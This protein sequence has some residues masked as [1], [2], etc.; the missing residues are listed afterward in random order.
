MAS[1]LRGRL[2]KADPFYFSWMTFPGAIVAGQMARLPYE[3]VC[4]DM[5][6]GLAGF[7]DVASMSPAITASGKPLVLR[8]L[9]NDPGL[10]G[11][12]LDAGATAV[13]VPMVNT[14][15]QAEAVVKA[16]KYAPM[17]MR[18]WGG[19]AAVQAA[20]TV[21]ADYLKEAN[22]RTMI[23]AMIET[24]EALGNL[25]AIASTPGLDGLFVGPNDLSI[26]LGFGLGKDLKIPKLEAA[27]KAIA[28][29]AKKNSLVPGAFGGSPEAC[30]FFAGHGFRFI[31]AAT[32]VGLL[33]AGAKAL[34][35]QLAKI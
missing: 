6:H 24:E 34:Q 8:I 19:Y 31:A 4:I 29:A 2:A 1:D 11:Q 28:A 13:I 17:G 12:A 14:R 15:A 25:D 10:I 5:Q 30:A 22:S 27:I 32:D 21:P 3:A 20:G 18:S 33:A 9:W 16:A 26:S 7:T 35:D 23:F